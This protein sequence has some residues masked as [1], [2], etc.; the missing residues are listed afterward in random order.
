VQWTILGTVEVIGSAD[1]R[2]RCYQCSRAKP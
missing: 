2:D 1:E